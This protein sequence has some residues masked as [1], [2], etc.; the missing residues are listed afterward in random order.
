MDWS[1]VL[2]VNPTRPTNSLDGGGEKVI[3]M[4]SINYELCI[5]ELDR[6]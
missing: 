6:K 4:S 2:E 5:V 3:E 1:Y